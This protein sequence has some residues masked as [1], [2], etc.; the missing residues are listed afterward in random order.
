MLAFRQFLSAIE[1]KAVII[2]GAQ[3][4]LELTRS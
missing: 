1:G 4:R 3:S 2:E